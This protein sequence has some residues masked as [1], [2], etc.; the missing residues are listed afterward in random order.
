MAASII[1]KRISRWWQLWRHWSM[2]GKVLYLGLRRSCIKPWCITLFVQLE[3]QVFYSTVETAVWSFGSFQSWD[4]TW[5]WL[6]L[7]FS[8]QWIEPDSAWLSD[9]HMGKKRG[10]VSSP[11]ARSRSSIEP[12]PQCYVPG[13][14]AAFNASKR[15]RDA[16]CGLSNSWNNVEW[17]HITIS[18]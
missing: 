8:P 4:R 11:I 6:V 16:H 9:P 15:L 13:S 18:P 1:P 3:G 7:L 17:Y 5:T 12:T 2:P 14:I 10:G